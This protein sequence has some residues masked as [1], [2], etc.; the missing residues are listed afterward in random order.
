MNDLFPCGE[1][2][3]FIVFK[4]NVKSIIP[5]IF[6]VILTKKIVNFIKIKFLVKYTYNDYGC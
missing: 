1:E 3:S 2:S 4:F 6:V 5:H